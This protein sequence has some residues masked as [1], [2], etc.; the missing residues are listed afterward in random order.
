MWVFNHLRFRDRWI[1]PLVE[2]FWTGKT[3]PSKVSLQGTERKGI[4]SEGEG[5]SHHSICYE[6]GA[7][8]KWM[9]E[10]EAPVPQ[11][12]VMTWSDMDRYW[13][14]HHRSRMTGT[15]TEEETVVGSIDCPPGCISPSPHL[16]ETLRCKWIELNRMT[17]LHHRSPLLQLTQHPG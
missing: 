13:R 3:N 9:I 15:K 7:V 8:A 12:S 4:Q 10:N 6:D 1:F 5:E 17:C 16:P 2:T 11:K 14:M